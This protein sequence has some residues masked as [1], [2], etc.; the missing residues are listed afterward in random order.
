MSRCCLCAFALAVELMGGCSGASVVVERGGSL[1]EESRLSPATHQMIIGHPR[2]IEIG[3]QTRAPE[4]LFRS[5]NRSVWEGECAAIVG[6]Q[7]RGEPGTIVDVVMQ[8]RPLDGGGEGQVVCELR[9]V[10]SVSGHGTIFANASMG[11]LAA[12]M[13]YGEASDADGGELSYGGSGKFF[14]AA[15]GGVLAFAAALLQEVKPLEVVGDQRGLGLDADWLPVY[16]GNVQLQVRD[17]GVRGV[18]RGDE[19]SFVFVSL[20][21]DSESRNESICQAYAAL[22]SRAAGQRH[23][24]R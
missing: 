21:S 23:L 17:V 9:E 2:Y 20:P 19:V 14:V 12:G 13:P 7:L 8:A 22:S 11:P 1:A 16:C 5:S 18:A 24:P 10:V 4:S 15:G 6:Q 3:W